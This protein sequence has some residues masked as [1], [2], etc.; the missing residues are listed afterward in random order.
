[1]EDSL[2]TCVA[3]CMDGPMEDLAIWR[4]GFNPRPVH[5]GF[6]QA[7][8]VPDDAV[9]RRGFVE[10][11]PF[12]PPLH[13]G[14]APFSPHLT[15]IGSQDVVVR[16]RSNL[17]TQLNCREP[18]ITACIQAR[19]AG[20]LET[21][22][23]MTF[24]N[25]GRHGRSKAV[26]QDLQLPDSPTKQ[27]RQGRKISQPI[28]SN[29]IP[30]RSQ[31]RQPDNSTFY[32]Y[33]RRAT[34]CYQ[35]KIVYT[36]ICDFFALHGKYRPFYNFPKATQH[37][38]DGNSRG[39]VNTEL[40]LVA[41][42]VELST[43]QAHGSLLRRGQDLLLQTG[44]VDTAPRRVVTNT[45][46]GREICVLCH[47]AS[48]N[49]K[50]RDCKRYL[51]SPPCPRPLSL[52]AFAFRVGDCGRGLCRGGQGSN[53]KHSCNAKLYPPILLSLD[54]LMLPNLVTNKTFTQTGPKRDELE[55]MCISKCCCLEDGR[56]SARLLGLLLKGGAV[57]TTPPGNPTDATPPPPDGP[58]RWNSSASS[59]L[60]SPFTVTSDFYEA[61]LKFYFQDIPP[62]LASI[63]EAFLPPLDQRDT[64]TA[65][66]IRHRLPRSRDI[67]VLRADEGEVRR[68]WSSAVMNG[69]GK[70]EIPEK[71]RRPA[72]FSGTIPTCENLGATPL[73]FEP[74]SPWWEASAL[75]LEVILHNETL[76]K[77]A[78]LRP[79]SALQNIYG[80]LHHK[81]LPFN[82]TSWINQK[83]ERPREL[84]IGGL[85]G[86]LA[87]YTTLLSSFSSDVT[88]R[89]VA[90]DPLKRGCFAYN[91]STV[92]SHC[93]LLFL[94]AVPDKVSTFEINLRKESL[95]LPP[96]ILTGALGDMRAVKLVTMDGKVVPY[97]IME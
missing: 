18:T 2:D 57:V 82:D 34:E 51:V 67:E 92:T 38:S 60:Y 30:T 12:Q 88:K 25:A 43:R 16:S 80:S 65:L 94:E 83:R 27:P 36:M 58:T 89:D 29:V 41:E 95:P 91:P 48:T 8:I 14:A 73:R 1:M 64:N 46:V 37:L 33:F 4:T 49:F 40:I 78:E 97:L 85:D 9:V 61:L 96:N 79:H 28:R 11:L 87:I 19:V 39:I 32:F 81:T 72:S 31:P 42:M 7:G 21:S 45:C 56:C 3:A 15:F 47:R 6:S 10:D 74:N 70:R 90:S 20:L 77:N 53:V 50:Q 13:P 66:N 84:D 26:K 68:V 75:W 54:F 76:H 71:T 17:S 22:V 44:P 35:H 93:Y 52:A 69:W 24:R 63:R 5:S 62:P 55:E 86:R 59:A 23:S